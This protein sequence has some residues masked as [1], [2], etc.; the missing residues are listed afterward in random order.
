MQYIYDNITYAPFTYADAVSDSSL[1]TGA[2]ESG[3]VTGNLASSTSK[4][5]NKVELYRL[6]AGNQTARHRVD[7]GLL[8]PIKSESF[9]TLLNRK[10]TTL[11]ADPFSYTGTVAFFDCSILRKAFTYAHT[12]RLPD[13]RL[14]EHSPGI[15]HT[16]AKDLVL[17][18]AR[19]GT[20]E[21][22][23]DTFSSGKKAGGR[24]WRSWGVLLLETQ[25]VFFVGFRWPTLPLT[26]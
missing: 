7:M 11:F 12:V 15:D 14:Q 6:I 22:K 5:R 21:R 25:L 10:L 8:V 26:G 20:L 2:L 23:E 19:V 18:V 16:S 1:S 17:R 24:K 13:A 9:C 4:E 3:T